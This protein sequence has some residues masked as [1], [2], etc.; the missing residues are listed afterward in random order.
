MKKIDVLE[1]VVKEIQ[2]T[3]P[4]YVMVDGKQVESIFNKGKKRAYDRI[5]NL[6]NNIKMLDED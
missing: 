6:I 3:T 2:V 4:L 5:L 1:M